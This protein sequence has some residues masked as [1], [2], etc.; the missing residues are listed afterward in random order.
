MKNILQK[1][2][3]WKTPTLTKLD[4]RETLSGIDY[5]PVETSSGDPS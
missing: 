2:L 5:A 1:K 4:F 3:T